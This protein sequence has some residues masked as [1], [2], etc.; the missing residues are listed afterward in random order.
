MRPLRK[1]DAVAMPLGL[2]D[3]NTDRIFPSRFMRKPRSPAYPDY[4]LHD[5]RF[6]ADGKA[7]PGTPFSDPRYDGAEVLVAGRNFGEGSSR[8][9]AVYALMEY[10]FRVVIASGFG[11]IFAANALTN[12]LLVVD[13]DEKD[14]SAILETLEKANDPRLVVDLE[15]RTITGN[16]LDIGFDIAP[17]TRERLIGGLDDI[18]LSLQYRQEIDAFE[19]RQRETMPWA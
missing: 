14:V 7:R 15:S 10:G 17:G 3:L 8:E 19:A 13:L 9:G 4:C 1:V 2:A 18:A 11:E 5:L 12:G 6:D 16:G